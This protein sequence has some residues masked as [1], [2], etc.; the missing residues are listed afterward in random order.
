[1]NNLECCNPEYGCSHCFCS[2][3][4]NDGILPVCHNIEWHN[5][6]SMKDALLCSKCFKSIK[7]FCYKHL[8]STLIGTRDIKYEKLQDNHYRSEKIKWFE[9]LWKS[10]YE[11]RNTDQTR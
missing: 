6:N 9:E 4:W 8:W 7:Y 11:C 3:C 1:M 5:K 10:K 2:S